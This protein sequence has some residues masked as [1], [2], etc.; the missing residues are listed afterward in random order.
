MPSISRARL[1]TQFCWAIVFKIRIQNFGLGISSYKHPVISELK[2]KNF[3][4][5]S[6]IFQGSRILI[7]FSEN[8]KHAYRKVT[9]C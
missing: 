1:E 3:S 5:G 6:Q 9:K 4:K 8:V 7:L 2:L